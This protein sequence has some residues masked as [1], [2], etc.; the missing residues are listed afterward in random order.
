MLENRLHWYKS[1]NFRSSDTSQYLQTA[2]L[3]PNSLLPCKRDSGSEGT[4]FK[5]ELA[6]KSCGVDS[7]LPPPPP[8]LAAAPV[9]LPLRGR[10]PRLLT[11]VALVYVDGF[12]VI[13]GQILRLVVDRWEGVCLLYSPLADHPSGPEQVPVP[14][15]R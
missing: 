10:I 7:H 8:L 14:G 11:Q 6:E 13:V 12:R 2:K 5:P 1:G 15:Q 9:S 4:E 3:S